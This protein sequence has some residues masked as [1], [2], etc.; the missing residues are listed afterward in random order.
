MSPFSIA[1]EQLA[2]LGYHLLPVIPHDA[3]HGGKGKSPGSYRGGWQGMS[4]WQRYRDETLSGFLLT[5]ALQWPDANAGLVCGSQ[6]GK[7]L[8][9]VVLDFDAVDPDALDALLSVAPA[10]PMVKRG[11]K[12]ESRFYL[13]PKGLKTRSYDGPEGRLLDVLTGFD[14]RQTV[15]PPSIH[16]DTHQPYAWLRGPV[17]AADLPVLTEDDIAALEEALEQCGWD[18]ERR[19]VASDRPRKPAPVD[20]NP[21]DIWSETKAAALSNLDAWV[22][23]LGLYGCRP[24]RGGY[25]AV[26]TWRASSTGRPIPE[27]KL[28]LSI[29]RDGIKDFGT[30]DTYSAIDLVMV[31]RDCDQ[32]E[33]TDW[34]RERLGLKGDGGVVIALAEVGFPTSDPYHDLPEPLRPKASAPK[35][36]ENLAIEPQPPATPAFEVGAEPGPADSTGPDSELPDHLTRVPGLVGE[37]TDWIAD[38]ARKPQRGGALLAALELVGTAAGRKFA[39]PTLTGT[40][41]YGLF[42]APS[43]AAKDHPLKCIGRVLHACTMGHHYGPGGFMSLSAVINRLTRQPLT[44]TC[45][46]EFGAFLG[47][48]NGR[49]AS[50]H[51]KAITGIL[52]SA[53]GSSFDTMAMPEWAGRVG[54]PVHAPALSLYGVST[55]EEFFENLEGGDVFNGFLNRFL[56][57]STQQRVEEREPLADKMAVPAGVID[58]MLAVYEAGNPLTRATSHSSIADAPMIVVPWEDG[59]GSHAHRAYMALSEKIGRMEQD[60][61]FFTRTAEMA[62]RLAVIRAIG[63]NPKAPRV[64]LEDMDWGAELAMWSARQVLEMAGSYMAETQHQGEAQRV[65]RVLRRREWMP[66]RAVAQAMK[67]RIRAKDLKDVLDGLVDSGAVEIEERTPEAGGHKVKWYRR[68]G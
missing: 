46:D 58:A 28:N 37:I 13:A 24:A 53:W 45:I 35:M 64:T 44:L 62:Q 55:H 6:V 32:A 1:H 5:Q 19:G 18:R 38:S 60:Q 8:H 16:P 26:A 22:P 25:E 43:G 67:N 61:V 66:Y 49:K 23:A 47:R 52:R 29:Q 7:D 10:S 33:A 59:P 63:I 42:L 12:G 17:P 65:M 56:I 9:V 15:V 36:R 21:D 20:I 40:H 30:N 11:A 68:G 57:V 3:P 41:L 31:A 48:I 34:L 39:G 2:P 27:R 14:T 4:K 54:D 50:T 51:E